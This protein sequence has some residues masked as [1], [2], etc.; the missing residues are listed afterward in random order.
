MPAACSP[1]ATIPLAKKFNAGQKILFWLVIILGVAISFSGIALMFP[2]E[3]AM[4][5]KTFA[6]LH[7]IGFYYEPTVLTPMQ[8][9]QYSQVWHSI[10][11]LAFIAVILGHI[12]IGSI[13]MEG[14]FDAMGSGEV[15]TNWARE[16]HSLWM[17]KLE[18]KPKV[19]DADAVRTPAE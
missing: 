9:M 19:E 3:Y 4:F 18:G 12:Y 15:D 8:E 13:G 14:A 17:E 2:F 6:F 10:V 7:S 1:R 5:T 16:H 11:A